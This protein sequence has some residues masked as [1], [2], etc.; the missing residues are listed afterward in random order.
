MMSGRSACSI[1]SA[2]SPSPRPRS[3]ETRPLP[4]GDQ[5]LGNLGL[6][7]HDKNKRWRCD[8]AMASTVRTLPTLLR[9]TPHEDV[10]LGHRQPRATGQT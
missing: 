1:C 2:I 8:K 4:I 9:T 10:R 5:D 3:P 7:L 6:I